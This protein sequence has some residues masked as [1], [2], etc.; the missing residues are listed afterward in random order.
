M[1]KKETYSKV[2]SEGGIPMKSQ[3]RDFKKIVEHMKKKNYLKRLQQHSVAETEKQWQ[4]IVAQYK[5]TCKGWLRKYEHTLY[6][7]WVYQKD[8]KIKLSDNPIEICLVIRLMNEISSKE[9]NEDNIIRDTYKLCEQLRKTED[10]S[11]IRLAVHMENGGSIKDMT[12]EQFYALF[13]I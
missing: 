12:P 11:A 4:Q 3:R 10:F 7:E 8:K 2:A 9:I 5:E 13:H 6:E 1:F